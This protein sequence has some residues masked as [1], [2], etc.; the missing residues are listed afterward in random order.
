MEQNGYEIERTETW[1]RFDYDLVP[2]WS[3]DYAGKSE[4]LRFNRS[5]V[6]QILESCGGNAK[7]RGDNLYVLARNPE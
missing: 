1:D 2:L 6:T 3:F 7:N 5:R 4:K